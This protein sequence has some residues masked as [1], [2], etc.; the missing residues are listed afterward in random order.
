MDFD[1]AG[2]GAYTPGC[3]APPRHPLQQSPPAP[4]LHGKQTG[5]AAPATNFFWQPPASGRHLQ[6]QRRCRWLRAGAAVAAPWIAR[7]SQTDPRPPPRRRNRAHSRMCARTA[8]VRA[9]PAHARFFARMRAHAPVLTRNFACS[10]RPNPAAGRADAPNAAP[11]SRTG[12]LSR[13]T[14]PNK[15]AAAAGIRTFMQRGACRGPAAAA[16]AAAATASRSSSCGFPGK[17]QMR[18]QRRARR[19]A[20]A[21]AAAANAAA[22]RAVRAQTAGSAFLTPTAAMASP[23][24]KTAAFRALRARAAG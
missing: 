19:A 6:K 24:A 5:R 13:G 7:A 3:T 9:L 23:A 20:A 22:F 10:C 2:G 17:R 8:A 21:A 18:S 15:F 12:A 4:L 16:A 1:R 11:V 14:R